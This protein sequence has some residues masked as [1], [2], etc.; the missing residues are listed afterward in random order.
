M[1]AT[2]LSEVQ[3][4]GFVTSCGNIRE[5]LHLVTKAVVDDPRKLV[6]YAKILMETRQKLR[7]VDTE[8]E[9]G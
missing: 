6:P 8:H 5:I 2:M 4:R 1:D 3:K 9:E 7:L